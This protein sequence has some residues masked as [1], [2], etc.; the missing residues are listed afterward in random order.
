MSNTSFLTIGYA[1][2]VRTPFG[3]K[4]DKALILKGDS[5]LLDLSANGWRV[6]KATR[7]TVLTGQISNVNAKVKNTA[8]T[9]AVGMLD[10]TYLDLVM[11]M[12]KAPTSYRAVVT[13][14]KQPTGLLSGTFN[15]PGL[16]V[17]KPNNTAPIIRGR[18][19]L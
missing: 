14:V 15:V 5:V 2:K 12:T 16:N 1:F 13:S 6:K 10:P 7:F 19:H 18:K 11:A 17:L 9:I 4:P 3:D 8:A